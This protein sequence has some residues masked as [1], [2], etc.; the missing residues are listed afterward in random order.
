M[1]GGGG[2]AARAG[3]LGL[4][5]PW[6]RG[7]EAS[8]FLEPAVQGEVWQTLLAVVL[9]LGVGQVDRAG[10]AVV[11][12]LAVTNT[13]G[14]SR[15]S[16]MR[17]ARV[18]VGMSDQTWQSVAGTWAAIHGRY[19]TSGFRVDVVLHHYAD[20]AAITCWQLE[21]KGNFLQFY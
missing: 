19:R 10:T 21:A 11:G 6:T 7:V 20:F 13:E 17:A 3:T 1:T 5:G 14:E 18:V 2:P 4:V 15:A 12:D 9:Y 16:R 8:L